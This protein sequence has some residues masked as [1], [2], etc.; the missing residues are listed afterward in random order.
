[1]LLS[2]FTQK[3]RHIFAEKDLFVISKREKYALTTH[4]P[5]S[6]MN[7]TGKNSEFITVYNTKHLRLLKHMRINN[8]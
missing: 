2:L 4:L 6:L 1:M 5:H 8:V 3:S 7:K